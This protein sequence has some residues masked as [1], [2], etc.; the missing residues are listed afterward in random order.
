MALK[1]ILAMR[2]PCPSLLMAGSHPLFRIA[3]IVT[4]AVAAGCSSKSATPFRPVAHKTAPV[5]PWVLT[6]LDPTEPNPALLWNG[7][8]GIRI[9]RDGTGSGPMFLIDEYDTKAEEKIRE[10]QNVL[11]GTWTAGPDSV[12]LSPRG[13]ADYKQ[14][15]DIRSGLLTTTW[16]Q[17]VAG[18]MLQVDSVVAVEPNRREI[19]QD[20]T[21]TSN[22]YID[23][24]FQAR[25]S[26][27]N[28]TESRFGPR[29]FQ[30]LWP[31]SD[32]QINERDEVGPD[33][34]RHDP[35]AKEVSDWGPGFI[36]NAADKGRVLTFGRVLGVAP[37]PSQAKMVL[38]R[39][40]EAN[41]VASSDDT[42]PDVQESHWAY[43]DLAH[44]HPPTIDELMDQVKAGW[45]K[46]WKSDIEID[47]P[48]EDQ[49][50]VR[51]FLFYLRS[52]IDPNGKMSISPFGLSNTQYNGHVFWDAD[53]WVFPALALIEP[54]EARAI[55]NYRLE[56][57]E[58]AIDNEINF[59][60]PIKPHITEYEPYLLKRE[61]PKYAWESS[62][63]GRET[64][65]GPSTNEEHINGDV[66]WM[67][68][69]AAALGLIQA[70]SF[71]QAVKGAAKYWMERSSALEDA[72]NPELRSFKPLSG[73]E[74]RVI[75]RV[76]SPDESHIGDNDLYTNL[77]AQ[78]CVNGGNWERRVPPGDTGGMPVKTHGRDAHATF[79]LPRDKISFLTYDDD[80][81]RS[82]KQAAAVLSIYPLQ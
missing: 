75:E 51:S 5:D 52:A 14:T 67:L 54:E 62:V 61:F 30:W 8:I 37:S 46:R 64:I 7:Q 6:C 24:R 80:P 40:A 25:G 45:A 16:S 33:N 32:T 35:R 72:I 53:I 17:M 71:D 18:V 29:E 58:G 69:Q 82:Y 73:G 65:F 1:P 76:M 56:T 36:N 48:V 34:R 79:K 78:W 47:G 49:Q 27:L 21:I 59:R 57:R 70:Q 2:R 74:N 12:P 77:L 9:G 22:S 43:K 4:L 44:G 55:A 23:V 63:T 13:T 26:R 66:P 41:T 11:E 50:A 28:E 42:F 10:L 38:S 15:L 20:W 31:P 39:E 3:A 60:T 81:V 68:G 19:A